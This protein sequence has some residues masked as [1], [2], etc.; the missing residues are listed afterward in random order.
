MVTKGHINE[1]QY[2]QYELTRSVS[3]KPIGWSQSFLIQCDQGGVVSGGDHTD[4]GKQVGYVMWCG[5]DS[6]CIVVTVTNVSR[7]FGKDDFFSTIE[8]NVSFQF[9]RESN[10]CKKKTFFICKNTSSFFCFG[11]L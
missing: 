10:I 9:S 7:N 11:F 5:E 4:Q 1:I 8:G 2:V 3:S 6:C